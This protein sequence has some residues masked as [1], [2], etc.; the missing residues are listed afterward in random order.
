MDVAQ[1]AAATPGDDQ[2]LLTRD[3]IGQQVAARCVAH[4]R[5]RRDREMQVLAGLAVALGAGA[6]PA[7]LGPEVVLDAIVAQHR[8]ARVHVQVDRAAAAAIAAVGPA[9]RH[10]RLA[11]ERSR[12]VAT[13]A[14]ANGYR[15]LIEKHMT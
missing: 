1:T 13:V 9:A 7:G 15:Y 6:A 2:L 12:T 5:S 3:E 10:V 11:P 14:T 8:L 4:D